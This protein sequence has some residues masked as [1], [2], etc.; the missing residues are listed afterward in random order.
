ML[1]NNGLL[2]LLGFIKADGKFSF[3]PSGIHTYPNRDKDDDIIHNGCLLLESKG[4][5]ERTINEPN[6]VF[7]IPKQ[8]D[9][10][11]VHQRI[12]KTIK[13]CDVEIKKRRKAE[14]IESKND[15]EF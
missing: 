11:T 14:R 12:L 3:L 1:D 8:E 2:E 9:I 5:V 4:L 13:S 10:T 6:H 15:D 7:W